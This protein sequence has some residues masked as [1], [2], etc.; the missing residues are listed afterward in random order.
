MAYFELCTGSCK[1]WVIMGH[2][3]SVR[4]GPYVIKAQGFLLLPLS[5]FWGLLLKH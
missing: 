1:I 5:L 4:G 2:A 3:T